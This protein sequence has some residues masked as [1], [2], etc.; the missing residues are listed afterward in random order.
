MDLALVRSQFRLD[1]IFGSL[2]DP[3]GNELAVTLEHAYIDPNS[4]N[5]IPKLRDGTYR[6]VLGIHQLSHSRGNLE[7][8]EITNVPGH[9]GI[10]F[11]AGNR[12]DDSHGCVL[13]GRSIVDIGGMKGIT[14]SRLTFQHFL[15]AQSGDEFQLTVSSLT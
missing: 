12:M 11:H 7:T 3:D 14:A 8:F 1:G 13:L 5:P 15:D 9:T 4:H 10:L 2:K 6:C